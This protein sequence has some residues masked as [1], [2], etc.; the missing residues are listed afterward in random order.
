[1]KLELIVYH[2]NHVLCPQ[3]CS[4]CILWHGI[5]YPG[6][7]LWW[8]PSAIT[9]YCAIIMQCK[10]V[11]NIYMISQDESKVKRQIRNLVLLI[12][13]WT[14]VKSYKSYTWYSY[15]HWS[16]RLMSDVYLKW[17]YIRNKAC[18]RCICFFLIARKETAVH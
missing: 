14:I 17:Q 18:S 12:F 7:C 9:F 13:W 10:I 3:N 11:L 5:L 4:Y 1:M 2:K 6:L 15:I 8:F 16:H